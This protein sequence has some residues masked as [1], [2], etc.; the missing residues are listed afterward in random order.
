MHI[1]AAIGTPVVALFGPSGT[2]NWG[3]W[4]NSQKTGDK[5]QKSEINRLF[6]YPEQNGV[7][8]FGIHTVIQ[9]NWDCIPC[10]KDGCEGSKMSKCLEDIKPDEV[11]EVIVEKLKDSKGLN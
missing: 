4:D 1:A 3:P 10:F 6:P 7:Q 8:T 9:R 11:K 5:S 2:F